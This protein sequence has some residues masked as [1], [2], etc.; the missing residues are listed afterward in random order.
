MEQWEKWAIVLIFLVIVGF[1]AWCVARMMA[2]VFAYFWGIN[3]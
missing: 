3:V 1:S 2:S